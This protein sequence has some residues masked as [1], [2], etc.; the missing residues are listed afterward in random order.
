MPFSYLAGDV[1]PFWYRTCATCGP[2]LVFGGTPGRTI[3]DSAIGGPA[4]IYIMVTWEG[5][6]CY[7]Q[8]Y[9]APRAFNTAALLSRLYGVKRASIRLYHRVMM[10]YVRIVEPERINMG[11]TVYAFLTRQDYALNDREMCDNSDRSKDAQNETE[12]RQ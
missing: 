4:C 10:Q 2:F 1:D 11:E 6:W 9:T 8:S 7:L 5:E 3:V 12:N